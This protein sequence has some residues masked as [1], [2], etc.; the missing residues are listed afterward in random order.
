MSIAGWIHLAFQRSAEIGW[1]SLQV[2]AKTPRGWTIPTYSAEDFVLAREYRE[3]YNQIW[4]MIHANYLANLS[5]PSDECQ[6]DMNSILHDFYVAHETGFDAVNIHIGKQKWFDTRDEAFKNMTKNVEFILQQNKNKWYTPLFLFEITAWQGSELGTT[7]EELWY[8]YKNYLKGL[9]VQFCFDT[10]HAWA[11][12][13]NLENW[14]QILEQREEKIWLDVLYAFHLN[15]SK[16]LL[17]T[18]LDRHASLGKWAIW[19]LSLIPVIQWAGKNDRGIYIETIDPEL[20]PQEIQHIR[21]IIAGDD[22]TVK[23]LHKQDYKTQLLKK[24]QDMWWEQ[25][26]F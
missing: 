15:D 13:N 11:A 4:W 17:W 19:W 10:A 6:N 25:M 3:K 24:F 20:R 2:F 1:T 14:D 8:F 26:L 9:P 5:K 22:S 12:W 7:I 16:A 18:R 23:K 21:N